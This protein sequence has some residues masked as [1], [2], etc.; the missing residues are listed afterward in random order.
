[1]VSSASGYFDN[2]DSGSAADRLDAQIHYLYHRL[3]SLIETAKTAIEADIQRDNFLS[4]TQGWSIIVA[5]LKDIYSDILINN[6]TLA[7]LNAD[8]NSRDLFFQ[9]GF[10]GSYGIGFGAPLLVGLPDEFLDCGQYTFHNLVDKYGIDGI[11]QI[12]PYGGDDQRSSFLSEFDLI[13]RTELDCLLARTD[14][15]IEAAELDWALTEWIT[16]INLRL[17]L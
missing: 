15:N 9:Y 2:S 11:T 5:S 16:A 3:P 12:T 14:D 13:L 4:R 1:M 7:N 17:G 10:L 6:R 8:N